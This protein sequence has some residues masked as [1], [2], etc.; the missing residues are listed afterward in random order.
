MSIGYYRIGSVRMEVNGRAAI[1]RAAMDFTSIELSCERNQYLCAAS[2]KSEAALTLS[3][4][5]V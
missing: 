2:D 1:D 5:S 4:R 3:K